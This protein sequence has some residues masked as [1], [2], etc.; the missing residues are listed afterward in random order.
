MQIR[1]LYEKVRYQNDFIVSSWF[2]TK[3]NQLNFTSL[4][5]QEIKRI[6]TRASFLLASRKMPEW[7]SFP[8]FLYKKER[9]GQISERTSGFL[10]TILWPLFVPSHGTILK[11]SNR[12]EKI[13]ALD[14]RSLLS[15]LTG[16]PP[17]L[18]HRL[19]S[20]KF[21]QI[22]LPGSTTNNFHSEIQS[23]NDALVSNLRSL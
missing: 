18:S 11:S 22:T 17:T 7:L 6:S 19:A 15:L 23:I 10:Y 16:K 8:V 12:K 5:H 13:R 20:I 4:F 21:S 14:D 3:N 2:G 1:L 9:K